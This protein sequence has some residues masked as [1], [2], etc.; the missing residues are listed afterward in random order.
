VFIN[1]IPLRIST[2]SLPPWNVGVNDIKK[3]IQYH[4]DIREKPLLKNIT[5]HEFIDLRS[6]NNKILQK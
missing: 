4:P 3:E 5:G 1:K 2:F 6:V